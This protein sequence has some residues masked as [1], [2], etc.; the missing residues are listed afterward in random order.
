MFAGLIIGG[1]NAWN[2]VER[3]RRDESSQNGEGNG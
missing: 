2:W 1:I 3:S